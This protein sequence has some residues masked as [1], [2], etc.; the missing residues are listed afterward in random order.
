MKEIVEFLGDHH[1]TVVVPCMVVLLII[2]V[3]V[4]VKTICEFM[5]DADY[6]E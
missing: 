6:G 4:L 3:Y 2:V 1:Q 5:E